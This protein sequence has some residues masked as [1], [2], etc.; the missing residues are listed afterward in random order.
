MIGPMAESD[1][2][3]LEDLGTGETVS[4]GGMTRGAAGGAALATGML[5]GEYQL[6]EPIGEGGMG[7]VYAA[8]HPVIAKRA[9]IKVLHTELSANAEAVERFIQEAR[10]VNQIG[11]PNIVDIFSFGTLPDGRCYFVMEW[12]RGESLRQR[13]SRMRV[14]IGQALA[15]IETIAVALE[16]AH[17]NGIV[18]R[19]L[20]PDNIFLVEVKGAAPQVKLLDFGIA[21][22]LGTEAARIERTRTGNLLGTPAYMSPEQAR[23]HMVDHRTDIYALGCVAYELFTGSSPFPADNAA[24]MIAKHLMEPPP[25][26]L[27][28]N[29][30]L[31]PELDA[32]VTSMLAKD[33]NLRPTLAQIREQVGHALQYATLPGLG[34]RVLTP[35]H[36]ILHQRTPAT[37]GPHQTSDR[38]HTPRPSHT[39]AVPAP[40]VMTTDAGAPRSR[41]GLIL[42]SVVLAIAVGIAVFL[43]VSRTR[44]P[45][46]AGPTA[47][48]TEPVG[49]VVE[50]AV[51]PAFE[52]AERPTE[53]A[54]PAAADVTTEPA[55][56]DDPV[57]TATNAE[58][59]AASVKP[60]A[61]TKRGKKPAPPAT[62]RR[63]SIKKPVNDDDAAM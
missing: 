51:A 10:S 56:P 25:S 48:A 5:V 23:G 21:K 41:L 9:A 24:D 57:Q 16:A 17:E 19:D 60:A 1:K 50:P 53:P 7:R 30:Q 3:A 14:P 37:T 8:T 27:Q 36:G 46:A 47:P 62:K 28:A 42:V 49:P 31:S 38:L 55:Q 52:P 54:M 40:S 26:A 43:G 29:P 22:L 32:L 18:H 4:T 20:K 45:T 58:P 44:T 33:A 59:A 11:H 39:P 61:P 63:P 6:G 13:L 34:P 35:V 2:P 15:F 12:L